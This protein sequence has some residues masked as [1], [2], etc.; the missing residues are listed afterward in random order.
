MTRYLPTTILLLLF[1]VFASQLLTAPVCAADRVSE[2][3][4][5]YEREKAARERQ[6]E[7]EKRKEAQFNPQSLPRPEVCFDRFLTA[8]RSARSMKSLYKYLPESKEKNMRKPY[9]A[10]EKARKRKYYEERGTD[11]ETIEFFLMD[12]EKRSLE[13]YQS[14]AKKI[15]R[16]VSVTFDGKTAKLR[17]TAKV[18]RV[19]NGRS[20]PYG[21]ATITM[22]AEGKTWKFSG[23]SESDISYSSESALHEA[24]GYGK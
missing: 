4:R 3:R 9:T 10:E 15:R 22:I 11:P 21:S 14:I 16:F 20:Y 5:K 13:H 7:L 6:R 8:A 23:Y 2:L 18:H 24:V 1:A 17:V 19:K 12:P